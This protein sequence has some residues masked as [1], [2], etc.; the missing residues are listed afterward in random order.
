M[1]GAPVSSASDAPDTLVLSL[2]PSDVEIPD[3]GH[4]GYLEQPELVNAHLLD[5]LGG[6]L[7]RPG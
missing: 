2:R 3:G 6:P 5:F 4:F 7:G 1:I